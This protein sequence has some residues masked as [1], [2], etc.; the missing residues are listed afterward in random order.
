MA[1]D[2]VKQGGDV[3]K[4]KPAVERAW[5]HPQ[6]WPGMN[7]QGGATLRLVLVM[8]STSTKAQHH[9]RSCS[10]P[11]LRCKSYQTSPTASDP[12]SKIQ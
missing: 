2:S 12:S 8:E 9:Y 4:G 10:H 7:R 3:T 5:L 1:Q 6:R 11:K